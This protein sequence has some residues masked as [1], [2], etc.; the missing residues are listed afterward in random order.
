LPQ[1]PN[2]ATSSHAQAR[3]SLAL[4]VVWYSHTRE[5]D[6]R[7]APFTKRRRVGR[8]AT[9]RRRGWV[10]ICPSPFEK[11]LIE[12]GLGVGGPAHKNFS[13]SV[14]AATE[15][16]FS[17]VPFGVYEGGVSNA[18]LVRKHSMVVAVG[19]PIRLSHTGLVVGN[20]VG[21]I[22]RASESFSPKQFFGAR[23]AA[24]RPISRDGLRDGNHRHK[25]RKSKRH[26]AIAAAQP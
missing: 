12:K 20:E 8:C 21:K 19:R 6:S 2:T 5:N 14:L 22:G 15:V 9:E 16:F 4:A 7:R 23:T 3:S 24:K 18:G 26:R 11:G 1:K 10:V 25:I 13:W 17:L